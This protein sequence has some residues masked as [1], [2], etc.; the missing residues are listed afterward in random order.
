MILHGQIILT[1]RFLEKLVR[2]KIEQTAF[3]STERSQHALHSCSTR[4][5]RSLGFSA[6]LAFEVADCSTAP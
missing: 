1:A 6:A 5:L 4:L 2:K 3:K